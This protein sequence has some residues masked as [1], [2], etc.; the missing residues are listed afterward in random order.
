MRAI[1]LPAEFIANDKPLLIQ[2]D[3]NI[4]PI[5]KDPETTFGGD[6]ETTADYSDPFVAELDEEELDTLAA[7]TV[8]LRHKILDLRVSASSGSGDWLGT[9]DQ[10]RD[11]VA[12][13]STVFVSPCCLAC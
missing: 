12:K 10:G 1:G 5:L 9:D 13:S 2:Y 6:F 11:V 4:C 7:H 3:G 8:R